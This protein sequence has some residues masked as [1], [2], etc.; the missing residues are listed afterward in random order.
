MRIGFFDTALGSSQTAVA[1]LAHKSPA[2]VAMIQAS[3]RLPLLRLRPLA[4]H[5]ALAPSRLT[6]STAV[7]ALTVAMF[8]VAAACGTPEDDG[9]SGDKVDAGTGNEDTGINDDASINQDAGGND[10]KDA[11]GDDKDTGS[12]D[13]GPATDTDGDCPGGPGCVCQSASECDSSFCIETPKG[14][15]CAKTCVDACAKGFKCA[16]TSGSSGDTANICVPQWGRLCN[17]CGENKECVATGSPDAACVDQGNAGAFCG[18]K[19]IKDEDC[20][21]THACSKV[22]DVAGNDVSQCVPKGGA[23]CSCSPAAMKKQLSTRCF[24]QSGSQKCEGKRTCLL[25]GATGAPA[26]GGLSACLAP[27]PIAEV[28]DGSDNDCDGDVDEATC[29]DN[30]VCTQDTCEGKSGCKHDNKTGPCD[31]DDSLCTKNDSCKDGKCKAGALVICD[32]KNPCTEDVCD[33]KKGCQFKVQ[34]GTPCNADD[35]PCTANDKCEK[36]ACN[37]GPPKPCS[38]GDFCIKGKCS[39]TTGKCTYTP[40]VAVPCNDGNACTVDEICKNEQCTG[41]AATCDDNNKC[42]NDKCDPKKGCVHDSAAGSCDDNSKCTEKDACKNGACVGLPISV[43]GACDDKNP[44][45]ADTCKADKGCVNVPQSGP[46]CDDGNSCTKNDKCS[47]GVCK[48]GLN[49]CG[50][51]EDKDCEKLGGNKCNGVLLCDKK[52][53]PFTCKVNPLSVVKCDASNDGSCA[54]T[55][56]DSNTGKCKTT[57]KPNGIPCDADGSKCSQSD[58]CSDGQ[59]KP[60]KALDCDDKN[61]CTNDSCDKKAGCVHAP[62]N[63]LCDADGNKCTPIDKC[64]KGACVAGTLKKCDDAEVCTKDSCSAANG[65]C[66]NTPL[67]AACDD[68]NA[69]T[70][71]DACGATKTGKHTCLPGKTVPCS[72]GKACTFDAC[73]ANKG[74]VF[75]PL[76]NGAS[77]N[78]GNECTKADKCNNNACAG[79]TVVA[80]IACDDKNACTQDK[81]DSKSGCINTPLSGSSCD[82]GDACTVGDVC[83]AG[84][85][86]AGK[87][88]C[89]C[90]TDSDCKSKD[91]GNPCNG[92]LICLASGGKKQCQT[93]PKTVV[94]CDKSLNGPCQTNACDPFKGKCVLKKK[95]DGFGCDA[96]GSKCTPLDACKDGKCAAGKSLNCDDLNVCTIDKCDA[97]KGCV[98]VNNQGPCDADGNACTGGD[99][100]VSGKCTVGIAKPDC[101]DKNGCTADSCNKATGKCVYNPIKKSCDD[102]SQ[103]TSGDVCGTK[104]D[105]TWGCLAGKT[106]KCDDGN[107]CT[108]D[109]CA[110]EKGCQY[111]INTVSPVKCWTGAASAR[112]VGI[113]KD[114]TQKCKA[115]GSKTPCSGE[116]KAAAKEVCN[117]KDD[118]C[119]GKTDEGCAPTGVKVAYTSVGG[120]SVG[121]KYTARIASQSGGGTAAGT[122]QTLRVGWLSWLKALM[123]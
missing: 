6:A 105:K 93:D 76:P 83:A 63:A 27:K 97:A 81:C 110:P 48:A 13:A 88:T 17:P 58:A 36:G 89:A 114:G 11:G 100:C 1:F 30:K 43:T 44:C 9:A 49:T 113:C 120:A 60:G 109:T 55:S 7:R 65:S 31:A 78:D 104:A 8:V 39:I 71:G 29:N 53:L 87:N 3:R 101:D 92:T 37:P 47:Q 4:S 10:D 42:T 40:L 84:K 51:Q 86:K 18:S 19:C 111:K 54:K 119:N 52:Q 33:P 14:N 15:V 25:D 28:C 46:T 61:S 56:C 123:K 20:P 5:F 64:S 98:H 50:C 34:T 117:G 106:I 59:C 112:G 75:K 91:D 90:Q 26:G 24:V 77:C 115:D 73:D 16:T 79:T 66:V 12:T 57:K 69:C 21:D 67:Y 80:A 68:G 121:N 102:G 108:L 35:N 99:K 38:S 95:A 62:N 122:K 23:A 82:D 41:K 2:S 32:D 70:V 85:C 74:C 22:K 72:D 45:T 94:N 116:T 118:T 103:C 96:D 107:D